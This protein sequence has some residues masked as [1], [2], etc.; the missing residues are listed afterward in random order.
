[1]APDDDKK[2]TDG[3]V[4]TTLAT[5]QESLLKRMEEGFAAI[6]IRI[7]ALEEKAIGDDLMLKPADLQ[8]LNSS[9]VTAVAILKDSR[10]LFSSPLAQKIRPA[11]E[12]A[13]AAVHGDSANHWA[14]D[15]PMMGP[16]LDDQGGL[17]AHGPCWDSTMVGPL[18]KHMEDAMGSALFEKKGE[19]NT[20]DLQGRMRNASSMKTTGNN[21]RR[22]YDHRNKFGQYHGGTNMGRFGGRGR[23]RVAASGFAEKRNVTEKVVDKRSEGE[24]TK[25]APSQVFVQKQPQGMVDQA[26]QQRQVIMDGEG[27]NSG[28]EKEATGAKK[29]DKSAEKLRCFRCG[30]PGHFSIECKVDICVF[31]ESSEHKDDECPLHKMKKSMLSLY[32]YCHEELAFVEVEPTPDFKPKSDNG[33]MCRITVTGGS[34]SIDKIIERLRWCIDDTFQ[35]DVQPQGT[36][37][38][39]TQFPSKIELQRAVRIGVF[40]VKDSACALEFA[41]WKSVVKP[42]VQLQEVWVLISGAPESM[43]RNYLICWGMGR[44]IGKT[45]KIDMAYTRE[46]GVVRALVKVVDVASIPYK[47][48]IFHEDEGYYLTFEIEEEVDM[49]EDDGPTNGDDKDFNSREKEHEKRKDP[50]GDNSKNGNSSREPQAKNDFPMTGGN[51]GSDVNKGARTAAL[52][53]LPDIAPYSVVEADSFAKN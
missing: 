36:N 39:K 47:K 27:S 24:P 35:W 46:Y 1:M 16:V 34:L 51:G 48:L 22:P 12:A 38:Y 20:V 52:Q 26:G 33:R 3:D 28:K 40:P 4:A 14:H 13:T 31:C 29:K 41:E 17:S 37:I 11:D 50:K 44:F 15:E 32:G 19:K 25:A 10:P 7:K 9:G 5:M 23:G 43:Y 21:F 45:K 42:T 6:D 30:V 2:T 18:E 53:T 49:V 8:P